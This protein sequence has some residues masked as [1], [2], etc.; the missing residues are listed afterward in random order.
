MDWSRSWPRYPNVSAVWCEMRFS[1]RAVK[2]LPRTWFMSVTVLSLPERE[3]NSAASF[4]DSRRWCSSRAWWMQ[5]EG[6]PF[7]RSMRQVRPSEV[8]RRH[9]LLLGSWESEFIGTS[10][11]DGNA[12]DTLRAPRQEEERIWLGDAATSALATGRRLLQAKCY[13]NRHVS[14]NIILRHI[15]LRATENTGF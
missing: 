5:K 1:A 13:R 9:L 14:V 12:T 3:A 2:T 4:S 7:L 6:W 15:I 10:R 11:E 8:W